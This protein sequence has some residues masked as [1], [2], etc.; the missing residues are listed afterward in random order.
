MK[1]HWWIDLPW[2]LKA[3]LGSM[4]RDL[5][6]I[7]Q[8][9]AEL[10]PLFS[11]LERRQHESTSD[12]RRAV[13]DEIRLLRD[14]E[15]SS[16]AQ[17]L[18][19]EIDLRREETRMLKGQTQ[20]LRG[21]IGEQ[22]LLAETAARQ[23][24]RAAAEARIRSRLIPPVAREPGLSVLIPN[25]N[26][27]RL[28]G[29][30]TASA[31]GSLD[32]LPTPGE[33]LILDDA[34]RDES[35]EVAQE[36]AGAD[37]RIR[38]I[39]VDENVGLPRARN[40]LLGQARFEHAML[41]DA[42]NQLVPSGV[43][44]LYASTLETAAVLAYGNLLRVDETGAVMGVMSNECASPDLANANWIDAMVLVRTER[45]LELGG[46]ECHWVYGLE[47]WELNLR[48]L[49]LGEPFAFVPVLVGKYR[50]SRLSMVNEAPDSIRHRR[51]ARMF[52]GDAARDSTRYRTCIHHP[53]IGYIRRSA[54]WPAPVRVAFAEPVAPASPS[55]LKVLV[56]TSGGVS[57]YGDDAILLSS[58]Q[59]LQRIRPGC[60]VSVISDGA[61]CPPL[62]RLGVW[63]GTC[64][65][66][67]RGLSPD[68][69]RHHDDKD[70]SVLACELSKLDLGT[71][72]QHN[73]REFDVVLIAGG[74]NLNIYWPGLIAR[75]AAIA[76]AARSVGVPYVLSGQGVGPISQEI[77]PL[78]SFL[79]GGATAVATRD[80]LSLEML[81]QIAPLGPRLSM[82]GD[83]ALGLH[84]EDEHVT[85][86]RLAEIGVPM[87][88]PL[89]GF[90]AREAAYVGFSRDELLETARQVDDFAAEN[91]YVVAAVSINMQSHGTE[92]ELLA[93]LAHG[94]RRRA[95]WHIV[96]RGGDVAAIAGAIKACSTFLTHSYHAA[97][98]ALESRI[99]TLLFARTEYYQ[100]K[101]EG[102][103]TAFGIP[104]PIIARPQLEGGSLAASVRDVSQST[105]TRAMA[106]SDVDAWLDE[107]L[108]RHGNDGA[109]HPGSNHPPLCTVGSPDRLRS[110]RV[111]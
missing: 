73:L 106:S 87:D 35:R 83:D 16:L 75:R 21:E 23:S 60:L 90:H 6:E 9:I 89:L 67:C 103:R 52:A 27:S 63:L 42:D 91:G 31:C 39:L 109:K 30:A 99:P 84:C 28:L 36:L 72:A 40:I 26:H 70:D 47:D 79:V 85:R 51:I 104:V 44:A 38:L 108:P 48:L 80:Q 68:A 32:A 7:R 76:A 25:W 93:E 3:V 17:L 105:W 61:I 14:T 33:V 101:G 2:K 62:G 1:I 49:R 64:E 78:L 58:L 110:R 66:F 98:F 86:A 24:Q 41:L 69:G 92:A 5:A 59:R 56:V 4:R 55:P 19:R 74:G 34:S 107:I 10:E 11:T 29:L 15:I 12:F 94:H 22:G 77:I 71:D 95:Q 97:L 54:D 102:L 96:N 100:L 88:R 57:N 50:T 65:E 53:A 45:I 20:M 8:S 46:Y 81:R 43:A 13:I 82:I 18:A 111:G 37:E